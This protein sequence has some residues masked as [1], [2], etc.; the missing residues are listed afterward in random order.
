MGRISGLGINQVSSPV[1]VKMEEEI[2]RYGHV[3]EAT[4]IRARR[5][6]LVAGWMAMNGAVVASGL[7]PAS[8]RHLLYRR[9]ALRIHCAY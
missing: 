5:P 4:E 2:Q 3:L 6:S 1:R 8:L 7:I 9:I